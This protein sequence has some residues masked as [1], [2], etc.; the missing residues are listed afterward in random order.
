MEVSIQ[1]KEKIE[2]ASQ[3]AMECG[4]EFITPEHLLRVIMST[5]QVDYPK[6]A[7]QI[8]VETL[9]KMLEIF[10]LQMDRVDEEKDFIPTFSFFMQSFF[11]SV[12]HIVASR[13]IKIVYLHD[14]FFFFFHEEKSYISYILR[15]CLMV[16]F[17]KFITLLIADSFDNEEN[18]LDVWFDNDNDFEFEDDL[19]DDTN[20]LSFVQ[21]LNDE[22]EN[23]NPLVG[24]DAELERTIQVLCRKDKNNVIHIGE[25]GVGKTALI[26]G[27]VAR[28]KEKKVPEKLLNSTVYQLD[29]GTV[30]AGTQYRGEFEE[31]FKK[32]LE[33][34]SNKP[35]TILYIDEIHN[36]VGA[37]AVSNSSL[38]VANLL[39]PHL[40][41]GKIM[42][43]G[44]TT[45][46]EYNQNLLPHKSLTRRFQQI[47]V[48]ELSAKETIEI[49]ETIKSRYE[50]HHHVTYDKEVIAYAVTASDK[51]ITNR[52]LPDKAIDLIDEAG[53]YVY[54]HNTLSSHSSE[55]TKEDID[56]ILQKVCKINAKVLQTNNNDELFTLKERMQERIYG[57]DFAIEKV[58][59]AVQMAKAGLIED[60]KPLANLL[61][62]GPTGVGKTEVAKE[63]SNQLGIE[64]V[65]FDMSEYAE[66]H[67]VAKLIGSPAGYI[68]YED[69]G[70]LTD[71]IRRT[72]NCVLL[73][74]EIEKAHEDIYN[75]LLQVMD[76][77]KLTDNKGQ[78]TDFRNVILILTSN[79]GAQ[80]AHQAGV[81]FEA[82]V[83]VGE[84]MLAQVKKKFKPEFISRLSATVVFNDMNEQMAN[85]IL[86][87]KLKGLEDKLTA[88]GITLNLSQQAQG[89]LLKQ[90]FTKRYGAREMDRA[91]TNH[92]TPLLMHEILFGK[93]KDGGCANVDFQ[94]EKL[95][96][97]VQKS[98]EMSS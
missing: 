53:S 9:T 12:E 49:L 75:I 46:K 86:Q 2:K 28:I 54:I 13:E 89:Y 3:Y 85:L 69:G 98:T 87:K 67:A 55:V 18:D 38:D 7:K 32:I 34:I 73:L 82:K 31:R 15:K 62:V 88:K 29:L 21:C 71:A 40:E 52:C 17:E 45:Y 91:I 70:L 79:I 33:G 58:V 97:N 44:A 96:L 11:E 63:L 24:R 4:H 80:Y 35:N 20:W 42:F 30:M 93:L 60:N 83:S 23:H 48:N 78:K 16:S 64:L 81:G 65:R 1:F 39:K 25:S 51:F 36:I 68:G 27:L 95:I 92:L 37:G 6:A 84:A 19:E 10:L 56:Y 66:K 26:Y 8:N 57:Q 41:M 76:Y 90:G 61:F 77:A 74:D 43:I 14:F 47:D 59:Q 94:A 72:P 22:V 50:K 5:F